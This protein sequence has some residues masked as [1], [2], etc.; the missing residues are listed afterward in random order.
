LLEANEF[1]RQW[2]G[3]HTSCP[4]NSLGMCRSAGHTCRLHAY[5]ID[6]TEAA[7][8]RVVIAVES[9]VETGVQ[10]AV[11]GCESSVGC[12][13]GFSTQSGAEEQGHLLK[14]I[15][16]LRVCYQACA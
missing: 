1:H 6:L 7:L 3:W 4:T 14:G 16:V 9:V 2:L 15:R 8:V 13:G 11:V 5:W 10:A 12:S